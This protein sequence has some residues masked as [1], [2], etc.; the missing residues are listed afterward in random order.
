MSFCCN[1]LLATIVVLLFWSNVMPNVF[2]SSRQACGNHGMLFEDSGTCTCFDCWAGDACEEQLRG[3]E[4]VVGADTGTPWIFEDYWIANPQPRLSL[5]PSYHL[6][7]GA[8]VPRLE[9]AIRALHELVGNFDTRGQHLV[10]GVGS[11]ELISAGLYA[12]AP[13]LVNGTSTGAKA[14]VW[15]KAPFYA[16][17]VDPAKYFRSEAFSWVP[18]AQPPAATEAAPVIELVTSPNN[19]DGR[20]RNASVSGPHTSVL[21]DHAYLWPHFT[22]IP[23]TPLAY[24]GSDSAIALFTL[25]KMTGHASTRIGWAFTPSKQVADRLRAFTTIVTIGT[26]RENQ[27]RA[28]RLLEHVVR[29]K[30]DIFTFARER[31]LGRWRDLEAIFEEVEGE[32]PAQFAALANGTA[33]P[34]ASL[35]LFRLTPREPPAFD[36]FSGEAG[37]EAS[38]AYAWLELTDT[39]AF[40]GDA[41]AAVRSVGILGRGGAQY[42]MSKAWVRLELL[43]RQESFVLLRDKLRGLVERHSAGSVGSVGSVGSK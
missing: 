23:P 3:D 5:L 28:A 34:N 30:G 17:Y 40:G 19:P 11:T 7:Y 21:Y 26:P 29:R 9:A 8:D 43:M 20:L 27:L 2:D 36:A 6:G 16:G 1:L 38:P 12:L 10:I 42:G 35:P 31:M 24:N 18:G 39:R 37:Y 32:G 25:S 41:V 33:V 22:S 15:A 13:Q 14:A 4:C